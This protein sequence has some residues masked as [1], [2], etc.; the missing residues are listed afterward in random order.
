MMEAGGLRP[1]A[2]GLRQLFGFDRI[3]W[4]YQIFSLFPASAPEG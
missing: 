4:I 3:Y 2:G 1:E